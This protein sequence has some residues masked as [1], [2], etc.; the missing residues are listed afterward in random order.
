MKNFITFLKEVFTFTNN[1][2]FVLDQH[3]LQWADEEKSKGE[4]PNVFSNIHFP[5]HPYGKNN[6]IPRTSTARTW[7]RV[8]HKNKVIH[9]VTPHS[10]TNVVARGF[11]PHVREKDAERDIQSRLDAIS[12]LRKIHPEYKIHHTGKMIH[13]DISEKDIAANT[14]NYDEHI[15]SLHDTLHRFYNPN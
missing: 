8:D 7:G 12:E 1:T 2:S 15:A 4:H 9:L 13:G 3:G 10:G 14:Q 6:N 11:D 5:G